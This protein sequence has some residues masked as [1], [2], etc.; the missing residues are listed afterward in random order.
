MDIQLREGVFERTCNYV[1]MNCAV[2]GLVIKELEKLDQNMLA[3][4]IETV[5]LRQVKEAMKKS[6][7]ETNQ[8][9]AIRQAE[10]ELIQCVRQ[11]RSALR[12]N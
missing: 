12:K 5:D 4:L 10:P 3:R 6:L 11:S 8:T 2:M 1:Q 9:W 7:N